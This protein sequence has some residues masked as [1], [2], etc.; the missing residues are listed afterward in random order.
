MTCRLARMP[1]VVLLASTFV[2]FFDLGSSVGSSLSFDEYRSRIEQ[3]LQVVKSGESELKPEET[4][5]LREFFPP[6]LHVKTREGSE[7][8]LYRNE[9]IASIDKA[10]KSREGRKS[11]VR[12]LEALLRQVFGH[13]AVIPLADQ[14]WKQSRTMLDGIYR[15]KEFEGLREQ[16]PPPWLEQL[17]DLLRRLSEWMGAAFRTI[18]EKLPGRWMRYVLCGFLLLVAGLL[19]FWLVRNLGPSG[20]RWRSVSLRTLP[21]AKPVERDWQHWRSKAVEE[22]SRGAFRDA[23][24][25]FFISVLMEGHERGWW[26]YNPEGTNREHL[27]RVKGPQERHEALRQLI[28]LY[29][30][31]WYG[32]EEAGSESYQSCAEWLRRMEAAS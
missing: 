2:F 12:F 4:A 24:R 31:L 1:W 20:R 13:R 7:V 30:K 17:S 10:G 15:L 19:I 11:L 6:G 16:Q 27:E 32:Q 5:R 14:D 8:L 21:S 28:Y 22:A 29:E 25:F 9:L 3:S 26:T 18:E 23:V